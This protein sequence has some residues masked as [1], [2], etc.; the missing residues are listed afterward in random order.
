MMANE[1]TAIA[2]T[3]DSGMKMATMLPATTITG[4]HF[5]GSFALSGH[6]NTANKPANAIAPSNPRTIH[7]KRRSKGTTSA[8][9]RMRL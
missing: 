2:A 4:A 6:N 5:G 7:M 9:A 3:N 8:T 1:R